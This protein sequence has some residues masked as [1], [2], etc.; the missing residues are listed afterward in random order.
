MIMELNH[1][2]QVAVEK[3]A[4]WY[5]NPSK[6][7]RPWF[8]LSGAAGTGKTTVVK[9]AM[10]YVGIPD[11]EAVFMAFVGKATLALRLTGLDARTIHNVIY[12][13]V[14]VYDRDEYGKVIISNGRP[15]MK[16]VFV[17]KDTIDPRIRQMVIDEGGMVGTVIGNDILSFQRPTL[18]LGDLQQLPPVMSKRMF[19]E[20]PDVTLTEIMRQEKDSPII[21]LSRYASHGIPIPYGVYG[22]RECI[23]LRKHELRDEHLA[24]SDIVICGTNSMRDTINQYMRKNIYHIDSNHI[25]VGDKLIC[26]QNKW[27]IK[28]DEDISLVNGLIGYVEKINMNTK[29]AGTMDID[30]RPEFYKDKRFKR[31]NINHKY[32]FLPYEK[33][34]VTNPAYSNGILFEFGYCITCHLAQGSQYDNVLVFVENV[35]NDSLYFRQWLYT[36][37]TRAKKRLILVI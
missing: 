17:K 37:I 28:L 14:T 19:L 25:E 1:M 22:D 9:E 31:L 35:G 21:R 2:Q 23:V 33:R 20:K 10:K 24:E 34:R 15:K 29:T 12:D 18:V 16:Q 13:L 36:A 8:E 26:R 11:E 6:R 4:E 30:C 7:T 5:N 32:P 27:A 3:Y